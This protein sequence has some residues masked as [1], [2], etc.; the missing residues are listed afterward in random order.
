MPETGPGTNQV[1]RKWFRLRAGVPRWQT[2]LASLACVTLVLFSW[3]FVTRG[4]AES[5]AVSPLALPSPAETWDRLPEVWDS[6]NESLHLLYNTG[7]TL[8]R[9]VLGFGLATLV[10]VPLGIFAGCFRRVEAFLLPLIV[11]GRNIPIAALTALT[12]LIF[13]ID[14]KQKV[15][16]IFIACVAFIVADSAQAIKDVAQRYV[17]TA[18]TLGANRWQTIRKVL[19]PLALPYICNSLRLLFGLA[20]GYIMLAEV[21]KS[22]DGVGGLGKMIEVAQ[23]RGI[24]EYVYIIVLVIPVVAWTI[25]L[26][27]YFLQCCLFP[28]RYGDELANSR[29]YRVALKVRRLFWSPAEPE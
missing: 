21:I 19:V 8:R 15:M 28:Y 14:E 17:D 16:F 4:E 24:R 20:F 5:R 6:E 13:G 29:L 11:F 2:A 3:W 25:D 7:V 10:G 1:R 9:V 22:G 26:C 12:F 18:Y 23:R 27:L